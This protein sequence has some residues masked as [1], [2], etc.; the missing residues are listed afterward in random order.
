MAEPPIES[1]FIGTIESYNESFVESGN[2]TNNIVIDPNGYKQ[3]ILQYAAEIPDLSRH[4]LLNQIVTNI[5]YSKSGVIAHTKAGLTIKAKKALCTFSLGVLQHDDVSFSPSLPSWKR[6][7]IANFH[8]ATY[9]KIF[10]RFPKKFWNDTEFILYADPDERGYYPVWQP[11]DTPGFFP[12][13]GILFAT[14]TGDQAYH[15]EHQTDEEVKDEFVSVLRDMF[16]PDNVP[17]PVEFKFP[18]WTRDPL[19]RGTFTNWGSGVT[20]KQQEDMKSP[21]GGELDSEATLW[22]AGEHTSRKYF[23]YLHGAYWEGRLAAAN[24]ADCILRDCITSEG[25]RIVK[26]NAGEFGS[27]KGEIKGRRRRMWT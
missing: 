24:M 11:L 26:R 20:V 13:S 21:V 18:R 6:E 2:G 1:S 27:S 19:F 10:A 23:G 12:G 15:A 4:V 25:T 8:M 22:F 9:T 14:V 5:T 7:A 16:G 3:V 17:E